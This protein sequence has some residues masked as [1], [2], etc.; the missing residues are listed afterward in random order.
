MAM[1]KVTEIFTR[2]GRKGESPWIAY[3]RNGNSAGGL[4]KETAITHYKLMFQDEVR[5]YGFDMNSIEKELWR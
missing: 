4:T 1:N 2:K 5:E 3:D